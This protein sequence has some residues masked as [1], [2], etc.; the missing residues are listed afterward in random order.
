MVAVKWILAVVVGALA[1]TVTGAATAA[2]P[3]I[4]FAED[5][6]KYSSDGGMALFNEMNKLGTTTNRVA[7]FYNADQPTTIQD[8]VFLDRMIPVAQAHRIQV[9]FAI[10]P[11]KPTMAPT[12]RQPPTRSATTR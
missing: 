8:Q 7:V 12:N 6:T 1:L 10:Y 11:Q 5:Q 3:Q 9:V 2:N 4:G